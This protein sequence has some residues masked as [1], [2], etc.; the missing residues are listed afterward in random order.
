MANLHYHVRIA[1]PL[2]EPFR[3]WVASYKHVIARE[4]GTVE[5][6]EHYHAWFCP[7]VGLEAIKKKIQK[8]C[9]ALGLETARGK[10]NSYYGGLKIWSLDYGYIVK[11]GDIVSSAQI[12]EDELQSAIEEGRAR[13][14]APKDTAAK[15]YTGTGTITPG[16]D[17]IP[18]I[19]V[20]KRQ[21]WDEKI[22]AAAEIDLGWK[23]NEQFTVEAFL[24]GSAQKAVERHITRFMK[25]RFNNH[26]AVKYAR[27]LLYYFADVDLSEL[28][29][30][31]YWEKIS[32]Y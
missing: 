2:L 11:E 1:P 15:V 30:K 27:N 19:K 6:R 3:E 18:V 32:W 22:I 4:H 20:T 12:S 10:S 31:R 5:G 23:P 29:E 8:W 24:E 13:W 7:D 26:E 28:L 16:P 14:R 17:V 21:R 25:A 9:A